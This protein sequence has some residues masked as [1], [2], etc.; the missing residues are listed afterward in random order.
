M[1]IV[2]EIAIARIIFHL[3]PSVPPTVISSIIRLVTP[4]VGHKM[5]IPDKYAAFKS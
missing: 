1:N 3:N 4:V 2:I 5:F